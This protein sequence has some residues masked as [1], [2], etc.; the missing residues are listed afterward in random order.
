MPCPFA[1][2]LLAALAPIARAEDGPI[3]PVA[4]ER[5]T[6]VSYLNEVLDL[7]DARCL[8]C[9]NTAISENGLNIEEI[10]GM[11]AGGDAGPALVPGKADES[12]L[13]LLA[14][15]RAEPYMP[16]AGE[17]LG[18]MTP[19]ELGLLRRWINEGARDDTDEVLAAME[20]EEAEPT[21]ELGSLPPGVHPILALDLTADGSHVAIGRGDVV[22]V[23]DPDSGLEVVT[24]GGHRDLIQAVRYSPNGRQLAIGGYRIVTLWDAP[25]GALERTYD[26]HEGPVSAIATSAVGGVILSAALDATLRLWD[27][28]DGSERLR[29]DHPDGPATALGLAPDATIAATGSEDGTIRLWSTVDGASIGEWKTDGGP[30]RALALLGPVASRIASASDDG[31]VR[32]WPLP[33]GPDLDAAP[34]VLEGHDGPIHALAASPDGT[35]LTTGGQDGTVRRWDLDGAGSSVAIATFDGPVR[36]LAWSPD[37][38]TVLGGLDDGTARTWSIPDGTP[39]L[40]LEGHVEG[41]RDVAFSPSGDRLATAGSTGLKVWEAGTGVGVVAFGH[42]DPDAPET[43][44]PIRAIAFAGD[45]LIVSGAKDQA[46]KSWSYDGRWSPRATFGPH[47][48]RVLAIDFSPDG[49]RL[50]TGGGDPSRSGEVLLWDLASGDRVAEFPELHSDTVFGL[51]F[52]PDGTHLATAS[53]DRF[54]KVIA[55][56]GGAVERTFEGHTHHVMAVDWNLDGTQLVSGS[57]DKTLK[58][59]DFSNGEQLRTG[60]EA[61]GEIASVRWVPGTPNIYGASGDATVRRWSAENGRIDQTLTGPSDHVYAVDTTADGSLVAAGDADGVLHLYRAEDSRLLRAIAP[62]PSGRAEPTLAVRGD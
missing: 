52:S 18:A 4:P 34:I 46:V 36:A 10:A 21:I 60:Q 47:V 12:L 22:Q 55:V 27:A 25:R 20:A 24:L 26:G 28:N 7:L 49:T 43:P 1:L 33:E 8:G 15:H 40:V 11:I 37:G 53:A 23:F 2:L 45:G 58:V 31:K 6:P 17:D 62:P 39:G 59:W 54:L 30:V 14:A 19:E 13:Y 61:D 51:R 44:S 3:E 57:A 9:H 32:L 48:S 29:I 35:T 5:D 38:K 41:V 42:S 50:A 16:P 56:P